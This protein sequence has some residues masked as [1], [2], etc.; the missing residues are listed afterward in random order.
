MVRRRGVLIGGLLGAASLGTG[1]LDLLGGDQ[2]VRRRLG[3]TGPV[4][5]IPPVNPAT[6]LSQRFHSAARGREV[7]AVAIVPADVEDRSA[8]PVCLVL[9]GRDGN[10]RTAMTSGLP[11]FLAAQA[12]PIALLAVDGGSDTWWIERRA[13]DDPQAMLRDEAPAWAA[14]MGLG[15][16]R[17]ALGTSAGG[18]GA[19]NLAR[20]TPLAAVAAV[21]PAVFARWSD[22]RR[23]D[24]FASEESWREHEPLLHV[25]DLPDDTAVGVWCGRE[26]PLYDA[27]LTLA[28]ATR[29]EFASFGHGAHDNAYWYRA[30]PS[31]L[32]FLSTHLARPAS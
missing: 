19:L 28:Q 9:H 16:V 23:L 11:W 29:A 12:G 17:G 10:A 2:G 1:V 24:A 25:D 13:G 31:A 26:D 22:A 27:S 8:L 21:S 30:L 5:R 3:L 18:A 4:G 14:E 6:V 20:R 15:P 7:E 32:A